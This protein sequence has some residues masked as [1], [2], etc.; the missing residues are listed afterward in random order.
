[1]VF[2]KKV[3]VDSK[4]VDIADILPGKEN[5]LIKVRVLHLWKVP[6]F[7]NPCESSS[8]EMFLADEKGGK[9]HATIRKQLI[10]MF[11]RKYIAFVSDEL[12]GEIGTQRCNGKS[13]F[14]GHPS[15]SVYVNGWG[16]TGK[17]KTI[18]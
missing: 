13:K 1:M 18:K 12:Y 15:V 3:S 2:N 10:Y 8:I 6:A 9:I 4:F 7:L 5:A 14:V 11:Q 17:R 16:I